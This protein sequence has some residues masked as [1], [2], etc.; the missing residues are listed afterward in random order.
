MCGL[1]CRHRYRTGADG[2]TC[3]QHNNERMPAM[4]PCSH[5]SS[6]ADGACANGN[7]AEHCRESA[8]SLACAVHHQRH[9]A[10]GP[11]L[12]DDSAAAQVRECGGG[13]A[14]AAAVAEAAS[15]R[16]LQAA[17]LW[18]AA[19]DGDVE[20]CRQRLQE[21][22]DVNG[23][24]DCK[25]SPLFYACMAGHAEVVRL[26]LQ[27][28]ARDNPVAK[29]CLRATTDEDVVQLLQAHYEALAHSWHQ[30]CAPGRCQDDRWER[31]VTQPVV[32][33]LAFLREHHCPP[34]P[35]TVRFA[36]EQAVPDEWLAA[37]LEECSC[38]RRPR[39]TA[40]EPLDSHTA[41]DDAVDSSTFLG[42]LDSITA[43]RKGFSEERQ[44]NEYDDGG[45]RLS[46]SLDDAT[47]QEVAWSLE[48]MVEINMCKICFTAIANCCIVPCG[49][50]AFCMECMEEV[51]E[52]PTCRTA[53]QQKLRVYRS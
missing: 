43:L 3:R 48:D 25:R 49:H 32:R 51:E 2:L 45:L 18:V 11:S 22:A 24:D 44:G 37:E 20:A 34:A 9:E 28:G 39:A 15:A 16:G 10:A 14:V 31:R 4:R 29:A 30:R 17:S 1:H 5:C 50:L 6:P 46:S 35:G 27:S 40:D 8:A 7:C 38:R 53:V 42:A 41:A 47:A 52:C 33:L 26:L 36:M 19:R 21:G 23:L 12:A 13:G